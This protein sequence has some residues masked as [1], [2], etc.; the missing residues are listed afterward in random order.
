MFM[1]SVLWFNIS[2]NF[3]SFLWW[4]INLRWCKKFRYIGY[5]GVLRNCK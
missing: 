5:N 1:V 4:E 2:W 3:Y